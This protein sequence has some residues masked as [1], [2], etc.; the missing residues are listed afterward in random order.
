MALRGAS[1]WGFFFFLFP[2]PR[3]TLTGC[4]DAL[5]SNYPI[6]PDCALT[7]PFGGQLALSAKLKDAQ[8][9]CELCCPLASADRRQESEEFVFPRI[10]RRQRFLPVLVWLKII[11]FKNKTSNSRLFGLFANLERVAT[12]LRRSN[13]RFNQFERGPGCLKRQ[14]KL[15]SRSCNTASA[16][17][18]FL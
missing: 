18:Q 14:H 16:S 3:L 6:K 17:Q 10:E 12:L 2:H 1:W 8:T 15:K 5:T 11:H 13:A 7:C 4:T 9:F